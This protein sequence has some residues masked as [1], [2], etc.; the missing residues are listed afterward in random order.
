M[1]AFISKSTARAKGN[2]MLRP[3]GFVLLGIEDKVH[4]IGVNLARVKII[5]YTICI[6][7]HLFNNH[8]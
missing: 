2:A 6:E 4:Q 5:V 8:S 1:T 7:D 3:I